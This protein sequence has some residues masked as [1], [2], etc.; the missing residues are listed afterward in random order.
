[1]TKKTTTK[2][3]RGYNYIKVR[4]GI[5]EYVVCFN[6]KTGLWARQAMLPKN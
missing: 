3:V 4:H 2:W 5:H 6:K 1:M